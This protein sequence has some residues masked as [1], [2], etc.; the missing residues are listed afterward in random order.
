MVDDELARTGLEALAVPIAC[1]MEDSLDSALNPASTTA[2]YTDNADIL[3]RAGTD[4]AQLAAAM[5][6][7]IRRAKAA[8]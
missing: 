6:I 7:L 8:P 4:I 5:A 1:I 2:G 3:A